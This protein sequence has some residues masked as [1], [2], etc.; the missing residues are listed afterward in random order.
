MYV[1]QATVCVFESFVHRAN[2]YAVLK[3]SSRKPPY[4]HTFV[5]YRQAKKKDRQPL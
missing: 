3:R 5:R 4:S 1:N 2:T